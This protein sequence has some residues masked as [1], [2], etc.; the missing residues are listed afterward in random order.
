MLSDSCVEGAASLLLV[1]PHR[2]DQHTGQRAIL[3]AYLAE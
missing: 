2:I 1:G 3:H